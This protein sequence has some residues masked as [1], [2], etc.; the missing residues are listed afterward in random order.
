MLPSGSQTVTLTPAQL[1]DLARKYA[2]DDSPL[3]QG[4]RLLLDLD[5]RLD[6]L[7]PQVSG[8]A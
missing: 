3:G 2:G 4:M 7:N 8:S 5:D 6:A 1:D